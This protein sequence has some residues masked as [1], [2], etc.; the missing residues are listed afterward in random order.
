V[1]ETIRETI[2]AA[3]E[4][5]GAAET[6][7]AVGHVNPD[8]D[9]LGSALALALSARRA[10]VD[11]V[12]SFGTPFRV[13]DT[14]AY[15]ELG[16]VVAAADVPDAPD[17]V[18]VFDA[19][20]P[21]RIGDLSA[22]ADRAR[23]V[24]VVD[25]HLTESPFGDVRVVDPEAGASALLAYHLIREL[26]WP[27]DEAVGA[28]LLTGIVTDTGRFQYSSTD[29]AILRAAADLVAVGVRPEVL[30]QHLYE[31]APFGYLKV[32][33][34]VLGRARLE[35]ESRLVWSVAYT[36]DLE[37]ADV[38]WEDCDG[39]I[40][41]LR[42]AREADVA[43]LLKEVEGG[44]KASLRSRGRV[45]VEAIAAAHGGGGHHNAAGFTTAGGVD[46]AIAAVRA[47]LR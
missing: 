47:L 16:P 28:A 33:A 10:G 39:L 24:V 34:A 3:A 25:H 45:D 40:D 8:G 13:P 37:A 9:A 7:V 32:A 19:A 11:A 44:F 6:I 21:E 30:G 17:V 38:G 26:G 4:I 43:V 46:E 18:V 31:S 23:R 35:P 5:I 20:S 2:R 12:V 15:L 36:A 29:P 27:I 1:K 14:F 42:I 22:V 41:D